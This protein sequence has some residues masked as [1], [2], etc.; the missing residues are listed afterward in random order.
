VVAD[1]S[2]TGIVPAGRPADETAVP[3]GAAMAS[4][5]TLIESMDC[6]GEYS[7]STDCCRF[8]CA[9]GAAEVEMAKTRRATLTVVSFMLLVN[10]SL[11]R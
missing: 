3:I 11:I 9:M 4:I 7:V 6:E 5:E 10:E 1:E 8:S 2:M